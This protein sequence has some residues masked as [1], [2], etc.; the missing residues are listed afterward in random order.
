MRALVVLFAP[1]VLYAQAFVEYAIPT[2][3]S[4]P[5]C[6]VADS[7]G[8]IWYAGFGTNRIGV[9]D[10]A[11]DR[12]REVA[13][14]TVGSRPH[15]IAVS[16]GDV[17]WVTLQAANRIARVD[18]ETL[19]ITEYPVP[20]PNSSPHTPIYDGRGAI[21]FTE[22]NGNRIGRLTIATG[23]MEEFEI[24]TPNS[25]P[26]GIVADAEGN[27]WFCSF[28]GGSNR[29]GR[30]DAR[31]GQITEFRTPTANSGPRRPWF[32]SR[33][34][35]WITLNRAHKIAMFDP[36][37]GTFREWDTP[38]RN[39]EPYGIVVD[40]S[41]QVWYN[42]FAANTLVRFDPATERFSV[43]AM[44]PPRALIRIVAVDPSNRVWY[45]NNGNSR[46]GMFTPGSVALNAASARPG[47]APGALFSVFGSHFT[48]EPAVT[49][50]EMPAPVLFASAGQINAQV[51]PEVAPGAGRLVVQRGSQLLLTQAITVE[52]A[53]P[54]IFTTNQQGDGPGVVT[55]ADFRLVTAQSPAGPGDFIVIWCTGLG[56]AETRASTQV[57]VAGRAAAVAYAGPAPG[58]VGLDQVNAQLPSGVPSGSQ[59]LQISAGGAASNTVTIALR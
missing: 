48:P 22:Q 2:P 58:F 44:P 41:D 57:S 26:Y 13:T 37:A 35:L 19:E 23:Q 45:G 46:V 38:T 12:F 20:T 28:G 8:R 6:V 42:E 14:P 34:R 25:G 17:I 21:W 43:F 40:R 29:I 18:P 27:A 50:N 47:F 32:D 5:H 59:P 10:P 36:A 52:A 11:T 51:P 16:A 7:R 3:N 1:V 33:G 24:P 53:A 39:G 4:A 49:I 31:T 9:Y 15:G 55:H 54:G 30:V 56:R